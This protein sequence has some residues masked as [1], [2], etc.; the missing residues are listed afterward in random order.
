MTKMNPRNI[1]MPD[2]L[3]W[4]IVQLALDASVEEGKRVSASEWIRRTLEKAVK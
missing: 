4:R 1:V 3:Y 2:K